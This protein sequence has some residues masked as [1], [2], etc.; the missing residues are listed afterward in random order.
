MISDSC[1]T[2]E[3]LEAKRV[4]L[5]CDQILPQAGSFVECASRALVGLSYILLTKVSS[6]ASSVVLVKH[7]H[8]LTEGL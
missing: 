5:G 8:F 7:Y 4:E 3:Y 2:R 1:L 6:S